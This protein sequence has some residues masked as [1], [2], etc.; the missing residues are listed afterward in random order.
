MGAGAC[1][2]PPPR[3]A[4]WPRQFFG[5]KRKVDCVAKRR[6]CAQQTDTLLPS[7][8]R[9][10]LRKKY[11]RRVNIERNILELLQIFSLF[12]LYIVKRLSKSC[13]HRNR[14]L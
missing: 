12:H 9:E 11:V 8:G 4:P 13:K 5:F 3:G 2:T 7:I 10:F 6:V 1:P 14:A